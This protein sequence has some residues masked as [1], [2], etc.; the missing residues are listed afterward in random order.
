MFPYSYL[1]YPGYVMPHTAMQPVDYRRIHE[2]NFPH[3]PGCDVPLRQYQHCSD[4]Q[5]ETTCV[6]AQTDPSE[7][8]N[9]LLECLDQLRCSDS[10]QTSG[11]VSP[12]TKEP[13]GEEERGTA[14]KNRI[15]ESNI[16]DDNR[17]T[18][19]SRSEIATQD[20]D[21]SLA[22]GREEEGKN[23]GAYHDCL[24]SHLDLSPS[25]S[26]QEKKQDE[27][28]QDEVG[29]TNKEMNGCIASRPTSHSSPVRSSLTRPDE[30][31]S[32]TQKPQ[33]LSCCI[34]HMPI[35][36]VLSSGV[37]G[38]SIT[39]SSLGSPLSC[40]YQPPQLAHE[41]VSVLSPSLDELSSHDELLSTDFD[42]VDLFPS[43]IY[44]RGKL[45]EVTS[46]RCHSSDLCMLYP[47]RLTCAMCG[48]HT[49]KELSRTRT[50]RYGNMEDSDDIVAERRL[51]NTAGKSHATRNALAVKTQSQ[52]RA[53]QRESGKS[54]GVAAFG[55]SE[56]RNVRVLDGE[57]R[58]ILLLV[59]CSKSKAMVVAASQHQPG[60]EAHAQSIPSG[61]APVQGPRHAGSNPFRGPN[62]NHLERQQ[63]GNWP[64][65]YVQPSQPYLPCQWPMPMPYVPFG[66]FPGMGYGMVLPPFPPSS[67]VDAPGYILPHTQLHMVDYRRMMTPHTAPTMAYQA[68]RFRYQQT[69]PSGRVMVSSEVQ[70]EPVCPNSQR[71]GCNVVTSTQSNSESGRSADS[72][73][74]CSS[75]P[76]EDQAAH[77]ET[78][79]TVAG[80]ATAQ[81]GGI[82]FE[83][84][85]VRIECSGA[86]SAMIAHSK[87]TAEV[88]SNVEGELLHC[89]VGSAED[90]LL[91]C[92]QPALFGD[93]AR[94]APKDR[95]QLEDPCPDILMVSCPSNGSVSTLEGSIV[96]PVEPVNSTLVVQG[97]PSSVKGTQDM[98]RNSKNSFK[99]LR[100]PVELQ[101][102]EE[103]RQMEASVWSVE[104]LMPYV[105][106]TEW[107]MQNSLIT[108]GKPSLATVMEAPT[109]SG[110]QLTPSLADSAPS[111]QD[112]GT[113]IELGRQDSMTSLESLPPFLSS[114][115]KLAKFGNTN[116]N[117]TSTV[118]KTSNSGNLLKKQPDA[119]LDIKV[120][121][122]HR[123]PD[124]VPKKLKD[125]MTKHSVVSTVSLNNRE[126]CA[127]T[128]FP[129]SPLKHKVRM[130][131]S[132]SVKRRGDV[133]PGTPNSKV[134]CMKRHK[135]SR[136][137]ST[138]DKIK[139]PLCATCLQAPEKKARCK[140]ATIAANNGSNNNMNNEMSEVSEND[141][142]TLKSCSKRLYNVQSRHSGKH[143]EKC[144]VSHQTK[145]REQNCSCEETKALLSTSAWNKNG[146]IQ[147]KDL[148]WERNEDNLA[149]SAVD[150]WTDSERRFSGEKS[151]RGS[152]QGSDSES[153]KSGGK[154][155][156]H[157]KKKQFT[158]SLG[159]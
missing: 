60:T 89:N 71:Q 128:L 110:L 37:Y 63:V 2:R 72:S 17:D 102:L 114:S 19:C 73:S 41:R 108:P 65:F 154:T 118:H 94:K 53:S 124:S 92:F 107:M 22:S 7:A 141:L 76:I 48:S 125:E 35:E 120:Q 81:N 145:L 156:T 20:E 123:S 104:S 126:N 158:P 45:A 115:S 59:S 33:D 121:C 133:C 3:S 13:K 23:V 32:V 148:A 95:S 56:L 97:D 87:K 96:A 57:E 138:G 90:V 27:K 86:P 1:Q 49:F 151:W 31:Q 74:V 137:H 21:S 77:P 113:V 39:P 144:P 75:I 6:G 38:S 62:P 55:A 8:L 134:G 98:F 29:Q 4:A 52:S 101:C 46:R 99:I 15:S 83:A 66:G 116:D 12:L 84:E 25:G 100:L 140:V 11:S 44:T 111:L 109:E 40:T 149:L 34:L 142:D 91:T 122:G 82:V 51:R 117:L 61:M 127:V 150:R 5:R 147:H 30:D 43:R 131:K 16:A 58:Q 159:K 18:S 10:S 79:C 68:R 24:G 88:A 69:I 130:C 64:F 78:G 152:T 129:E 28:V 153:S 132:C 112:I 146:H 36:K 47:K 67:Y 136:S 9:K 106:T 26:C 119:S 42:D 155:K 105:P 139:V 14:E 103:L 50:R 143:L 93:E 157:N 135:V 70:T 54:A 85:E 80:I